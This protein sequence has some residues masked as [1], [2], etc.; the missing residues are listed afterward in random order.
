M[1]TE[2]ITAQLAL[3]AANPI[4]S[5][6]R[7]LREADATLAEE[8]LTELFYYEGSAQYLSIELRGFPGNFG[9]K[10]IAEFLAD[11]LNS[12]GGSGSDN[13]RVSHFQE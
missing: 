8:V 13:A 9:T 4:K 11:E 1:E 12:A 3:R 7:L 5:L 10:T 2:P 6:M